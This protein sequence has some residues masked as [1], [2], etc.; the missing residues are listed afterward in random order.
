[1]VMLLLI[2]ALAGLLS[3][4]VDRTD[5]AGQ[6]KLAVRVFFIVG[7]VVL[8]TAQPARDSRAVTGGL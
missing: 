8:S 2:V 3:W 5:A 4:A 1:M 7:L 6:I